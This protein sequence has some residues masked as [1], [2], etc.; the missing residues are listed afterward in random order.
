VCMVPYHIIPYYTTVPYHLYGRVP[1]SSK[2]AGSLENLGSSVSTPY[3]HMVP[4]YHTTI[5]LHTSTR[6]PC[7]PPTNKY[8][9][10]TST[11]SSYRIRSHCTRA[12]ARVI[13]YNNL[14]HSADPT[15][16]F[17]FG[18]G[19][20]FACS[21]SQRTRFGDHR[22]QSRWYRLLPI[23]RL[24]DDESHSFFSRSFDWHCLP[25]KLFLFGW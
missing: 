18:L 1:Y 15:P 13:T 17:C 14:L 24:I 22:S 2:S 4:P 3:H 5:L 23:E 16:C 20:P 8:I 25:K 9:Y 21:H 12:P 10:H 7:S 19:S 6:P 11:V